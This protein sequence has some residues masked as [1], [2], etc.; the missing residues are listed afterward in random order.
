[1]HERQAA[2]MAILHR[3]AELK[4]ARIMRDNAALTRTFNLHNAPEN[5]DLVWVY[6]N[7][8]SWVGASACA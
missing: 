2:A 3:R 8:I 6:A 5:G 4:R 7:P 1:M